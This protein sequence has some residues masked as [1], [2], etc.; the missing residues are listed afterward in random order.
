M[1][2]PFFINF[3]SADEIT[4]L[5]SRHWYLCNGESH[6]VNSISRTTPDLR[7]RFIWGGADKNNDADPDSF[8]FQNDQWETSVGDSYNRFR[9]TVEQE[10]CG[11]T[12]VTLTSNQIPA[13]KHTFQKPAFDH[14][15]NPDL[16]SWN[17][18]IH[19][20]WYEKETHT[21]LSDSNHYTDGGK[22]L[23]SNSNVAGSLALES[24][25]HNNLPPYMVLAYFIYWPEPWDDEE[26]WA[27]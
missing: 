2:A 19:Y 14:I 27:T 21:R 18:D 5:E 3:N 17:H 8:V 10:C 22:V 16:R 23:D 25:P 12:E 6:D 15:S 7:G 1:I 26:P 4:K 24:Q 20:K 11:K 9:G 13:H